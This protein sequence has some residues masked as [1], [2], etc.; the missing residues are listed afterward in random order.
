MRQM[1]ENN[2][3]YLKMFPR[4]ERFVCT[5]SRRIQAHISSPLR[6]I[7]RFLKDYRVTISPLY[8]TQRV[9]AYHE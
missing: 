3:V 7:Q 8:Y 5:T 2:N 6:I 1:V 9:R 4:F